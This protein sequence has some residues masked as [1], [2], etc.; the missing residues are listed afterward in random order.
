LIAENAK[1]D[2]KSENVRLAD[3]VGHKVKVDGV[4]SNAALHG[5]K[6]DLKAEVDKTPTETRRPDCYEFR[7]G[8]R[9]LQLGFAGS[10]GA[11]RSEASALDVLPVHFLDLVL[12]PWPGSMLKG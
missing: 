9:Q 1:W 3:H 6:E 4:V 7:N 2:L 8:R 11:G 10:I 12:P 5:M